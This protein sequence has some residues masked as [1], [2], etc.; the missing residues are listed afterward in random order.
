M[1]P[2]KKWNPS[3]LIPLAAIIALAGTLAAG[4]IYLMGK[5]ERDSFV[6]PE[7]LSVVDTGSIIRESLPET[8]EN[9]ILNENGDFQPFQ[10]PEEALAIL[11]REDVGTGTDIPETEPETVEE[12]V[13]IETETEP[14]TEPETKAPETKKETKAPETKAPETKKETK[15]PETKAPETKPPETK[16]VGDAVQIGSG[17]SYLKPGAEKIKLFVLY[18]LDKKTSSDI[19]ILSALD[20]VHNKVKIISIARDTYT[21]LSDRNAHTKLTYAYSLGGAS[22]AVRALNENLYLHLEDYA[23]VDYTQAEELIDLLGGVEVEL[24]ETELSYLEGYGY[25]KD[26]K[27]GMNKLNGM[28]AVRYARLRQTD[29]DLVRNSRQREVISS[30]LTSFRNLKVT[31]YPALFREVAGMCTTSFTDT[32]IIGLGTTFLS[33]KGCTFEQYSYP[34]A[35]TNCWGGLIDEQFYWVYDLAKVSDEIYRII[36]EDLY[37]SGYTAK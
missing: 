26:I 29:N 37:V 1:K 34:N 17:I 5:M 28:Q 32:E 21:Y 12:I 9:G 30:L 31:D 24:D 2:R 7:E 23:A 10:L 25:F 36:Y 19:I 13:V 22:L 18:G 15:P 8:T 27:P 14:E 6:S 35:S 3:L 20:P 33:M 11:R 4:Y 16:P